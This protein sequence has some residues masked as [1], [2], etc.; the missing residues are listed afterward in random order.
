MSAGRGAGTRKGRAR[1]AGGIPQTEL[2]HLI[3]DIDVVHV[4]LEYCWFAGAAIEVGLGPWSGSR[5]SNGCECG[6]GTHYTC[7]KKPFVKTF[8]SEVLPVRDLWFG[9]RY[10]DKDM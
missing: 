2:H 5:C 6:R 1:R 8:S 3:V 4:V 10:S 7:V 9:G